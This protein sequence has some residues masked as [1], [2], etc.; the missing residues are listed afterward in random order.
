MRKLLL[1][2]LSLLVLVVIVAFAA[3]ALRWKRTFDAPLPDIHASTDSAVI[4]K[5]RYLVYGPANCA[6]CHVLRGE[7]ANLD[8]GAMPPLSGAHE[9]PLPFGRIYSAN[10]T[11]DPET[12]I[13]RRTDG[14]LARVLRHGVRADG[15]AAMPLMEYQNMSDEDLIAVISFLRSQAPV[16][17]PVPE[18]ELNLMG[19]ALFAF[20]IAPE[21]PRAVPPQ[22]SPASNAT[23]E[24]G[25]YLANDV[26]LC[27]SCHT[28]RDL[29]T[30]EQLGPKF[31]GGQRMDFAA[32]PSRVLVTPNITPDPETGVAARWSEDQFLARFR[33][34]PVIEETIMPW[35]GYARMTDD[36]L[37]AIYRYLRSLPPVRNATG[38]VLQEK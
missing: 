24:R 8:A 16:R 38:P 28:N 15:R 17:N 23:I 22:A 32:D 2:V 7:W 12:G 27:V 4:A 26:A 6:Y 14:E 34:G 13:G 11:P 25:E 18:H 19:K 31:A 5:G 36:D 35:G 29:R 1:A 37:R 3:V 10:L 33:Q 20:A 9:F 21:G 30:G